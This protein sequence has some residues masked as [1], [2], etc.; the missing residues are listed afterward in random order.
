MK[1]SLLIMLLLSVSIYGQVGINTTNPNATLDIRSSNQT[2]PQSTDGILIPKVDAF[3]AVNP[4][5]NQHGMLVYLTTTS[6]SK[7]PGFYY[8]DNTVPDWIGLGGGGGTSGWD[9][10]G[11][12]GT[13]GSTNFL[14]TT[15]NVPLS[16][17]TGNTERV[18]INTSGNVG[19]GTSYAASRL[20]VEG[21]MSIGSSY[22]GSYTAPTN[23]AIVEGNVG[24][25]VTFPT[26]Q[27]HTTGTARLANYPNAT[28]LSTDFQGN[29]QAN[30]GSFWSTNGNSN[31][32]FSS[33]LGTTDIFPLYFRYN[34]QKSGELSSNATSFGHNALAVNA[35][36][37]NTAFGIDAL[38]A[39]TSG[40]HNTAVGDG[41]MEKHISGLFNTAIGY[42]AMPEFV[43][44][45]ANVGVGTS[46]MRLMTSG[47]RNTAV[48]E[49][50]YTNYNSGDSNT[51][52]G[53]RSFNVNS[54]GSNFSNSVAIGQN[55][56]ISASNQI[57]LGF[58]SIT[59]IGGYA[60]WTNLS[61][62]RFKK[63]IKSD[64][65]GL[66]FIKKLNP[67]TYNLDMDAID[68][69][70]NVSDET[71]KATEKSKKNKED[72]V[73]TGFI[74]QEVEKAAKELNYDFSGVDKPKNAEDSYGLRY[75]EFVVPLVKA[76][77]ELEAKVAKLE[78]Q[79]ELL[80]KKKN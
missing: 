38:K 34:N 36:F 3:S 48:G 70:L 33:F 73:Q 58:S 41:A 66:A 64:V 61:D 59:S 43:S 30:T 27:L 71:K 63:N 51:A 17:R 42:G 62:G 26:A 16:F 10:I 50:A 39:N 68:D 65:P 7:S 60:N 78:K 25:G 11:N 22:S 67:V 57:R 55:T 76:V 47:D 46:V 13:N 75:A 79:L 77:Q 52:I 80:E 6:G 72:Q 21:G 28:F 24:I 53:F 29:L 56:Y 49:E 23:G 32:G 54:T 35:S 15:D 2:A 9:L 45:N 14:G 40:Y 69:W 1:K 8:W 31:V 37:G 44:G 18:R 74:A 20:D 5:A 12:S 4:T 19:I